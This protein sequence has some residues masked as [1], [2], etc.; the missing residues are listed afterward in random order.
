MGLI[1]FILG[2]HT[3]SQGNSRSTWSP[4]AIRCLNLDCPLRKQRPRLGSNWE[5][6]VG[7]GKITTIAH[8]VSRLDREECGVEKFLKLI[9]LSDL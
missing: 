9:D 7:K 4:S 5:V 2:E 6:G 1:V 3:Q 8:G